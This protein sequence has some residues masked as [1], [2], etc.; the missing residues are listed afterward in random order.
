MRVDPS[1]PEQRAIP[2]PGGVQNLAVGGGYVWVTNF[3]GDSV[4][5]VDVRNLERTQR[6]PVGKGPDGVVVGYGAV[7]VASSLDKSVTRI[8]PKTLKTRRIDLGVAPTR[9]AVG[10]GSVWATAREANRLFRIDPA[11]RKVE[12]RIDTGSGPYALDVAG[13]NTVWLTL[14][15]EGDGAIQRVRFYP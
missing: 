6:I 11:H 15:D 14:L 13:G 12:E 3:K 1:T 7:W 2:I 10:G 9:V 5:R 8:N 4:M